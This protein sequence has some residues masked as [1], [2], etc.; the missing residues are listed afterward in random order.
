[1]VKNDRKLDVVNIDLDSSCLSAIMRLLLVSYDVKLEGKGC[2]C[3][4]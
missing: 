3:H 2:Q 1:M 4:P